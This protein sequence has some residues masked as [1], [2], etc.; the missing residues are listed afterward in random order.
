VVLGDAPTGT[1]D[2]EIHYK[3]SDGS[4]DRTVAFYQTDDFNCYIT[5]NGELSFQ[6]RSSYLDAL[7]HNLDIF[8]TDEDFQTSWQ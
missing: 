4:E 2:A 6:C 1:P 7:R 8:D 5:V 3:T